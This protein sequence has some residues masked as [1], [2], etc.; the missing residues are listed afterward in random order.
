MG[1]L[2]AEAGP[3]LGGGPW[4]TKGELLAEPPPL[5]SGCSWGGTWKGT[6]KV[7]PH[8]CPRCQLDGDLAAEELT[9]AEAVVLASWNTRDR[10]HPKPC[11]NDMRAQ[12]GR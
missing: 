8:L 10:T 4:L 5:C 12:L 2:N 9:V 6:M 3:L 11:R 7:P 1:R